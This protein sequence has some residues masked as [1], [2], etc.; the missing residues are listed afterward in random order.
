MFIR[1]TPE[2]VSY[3]LDEIKDAVDLLDL[4]GSGHRATQ[5]DGGGGAYAGPCLGVAALTASWCGL[6][7]A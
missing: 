6:G 5:G 1:V 2:T 7:R 3:D 4:I